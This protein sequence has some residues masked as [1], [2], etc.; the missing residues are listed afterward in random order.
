M[1]VYPRMRQDVFTVLPLTRS[2]TP[3]CQWGDEDR[4]GGGRNS[5]SNSPVKNRIWKDNRQG[6]GI[7]I[8]PVTVAL[9]WAFIRPIN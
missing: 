2:L 3:A 8:L 1:F 7:V 5:G 9:F 4:D 6:G